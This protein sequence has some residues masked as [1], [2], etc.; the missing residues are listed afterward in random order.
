[1]QIITPLE[2]SYEQ[3][4]AMLRMMP[5]QEVRQKIWR[6]WKEE[7]KVIEVL[8]NDHPAHQIT[9]ATIDFIFI[10][11]NGVKRVATDRGALAKNV[12]VS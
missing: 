7:K 4:K 1:M 8:K 12:R 11:E 6:S 2:L 10:H 9:T 3:L 5:P